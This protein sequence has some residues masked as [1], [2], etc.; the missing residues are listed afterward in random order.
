MKVIAIDPG[1]DRL[2]VA[3]I[4][5]DTSSKERLIYSTCIETS[6][7]NIFTERLKKIGQEVRLLIK[8]YQ[9]DYM[10]I[11]D[12]FFAKNTKTA[13]KVSES[14]GVVI[15]QAVDNNIPVCEFTPNQI[16]VAVTGYGK[17]TKNDVYT[18]TMKLIKIDN[19]KR[20]DDEI[21]AIA[22]GL[23]FFATHKNYS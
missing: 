1:Y 2:G 23:T 22:T 6:P 10:A 9:P 13:L 11:E 16:K 8:E 12:L 17:A 21:D 7:E 15:F 4:E 5:K 3:I 19:Q 18:M 14:R 20:K